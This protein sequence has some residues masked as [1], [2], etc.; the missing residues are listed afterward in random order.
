MPVNRSALW[1]AVSLVAALALLVGCS[2]PAPSG[3]NPTAQEPASTT[4]APVPAAAGQETPPPA[5]PENPG[6]L[7]LWLPPQFDPSGNTPAAQILRQRL[8][9]FS[10]RYPDVTLD[11]RVKAVDGPGGLLD[12]LTTAS[13]AAPGALPDLVALPRELMETAALKGL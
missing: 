4:S 1:R 8:N 7:R 6:T 13:A 11:V 5:S 3:P 9:E 10:R 12:S 2:Q